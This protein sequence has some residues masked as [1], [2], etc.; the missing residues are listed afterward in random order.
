MRHLGIKTADEFNTQALELFHW[1]SEKNALYRDYLQLTGK[2]LTSVNHWREIPCLP[3][4]FFKTHSVKTGNWNEKLVFSSSGTTSQVTSR[5]YV[6]KPAEY[7]INFLENFRYFYGEPSQWC[8][9]AILPSYLERGNSSLVYM[10][11]G[12]IEKSRY[13]ESGFYTGKYAQTA[14][15]LSDLRDRN[16]PVILL[17]VTYALI[18]FAQEQ[19]VDFPGLVI[20]ET[21]G[22]KGRKRE[23]IRDEVHAI[24]RKGF[25]VEQVHSEYGMT[26]LFSQAYSKGEGKYECPPWMRI[27]LRD[28]NDPLSNALPGQTG[29]INIIDLANFDTCAFIAVQDLGRMDT[30]GRFEVLGRFDDSELRG[31]SLMMV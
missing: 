8:F 30:E 19:P 15:L 21:G 3:V 7:T 5:H 10:A 4:S 12:L 20:M 9:I 27:W 25:R 17:G 1:Q 29:G 22:M 14:A 24:L 13:A 2:D 16:I 28:T 31:C 11:N 23:M 6:K 18:D 26:E